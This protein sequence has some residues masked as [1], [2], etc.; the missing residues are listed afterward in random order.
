M[1]EK[2][3]LPW[4]FRVSTKHPASVDELFNKNVEKFVEKASLTIVSAHA[5]DT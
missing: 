3:H 4:L 2:R 5:A 1:P